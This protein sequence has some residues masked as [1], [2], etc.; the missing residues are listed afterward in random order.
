MIHANDPPMKWC[1][2]LAFNSESQWIDLA[3]TAE[4]AGFDSVV[5]SDHLIYPETLKTLYPY[6]KT[7]QPRWRPDTAWPDPLIALTALAVSTTKLRFITS[8]YTLPLR[9][10]VVAAKQ[11]ATAE[12]FSQSRLTL[13][14]G[15]GWMQEEFELLGQT[16][17]GR[18]RRMVEA[19]GIMKR[20]WEGGIV[21]HSGEFYEIPPL[22]INPTPIA[23]I[24]FWG[25]GTSE[26]ALTRAA[27]LFDGWLSE[28]QDTDELPGFIET[29]RSRRAD[30]PKSNEPFAINASIRDAYTLDHFR[31]LRDLGVTHVNVVPWLLQRMMEDNVEKK[32]GGIRRFGDEIIAKL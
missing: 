18:G 27:T 8:I 11:I 25:G 3:I 19:I 22:Q 30:S 10:P 26:I 1:M 2:P 28:V 13:G 32:C 17:E 4:K 14:V 31:R 23:P 12:I 24:P 20:L 15:I 9:H 7:G 16:F 29:L 6:T 5:I 21:Q